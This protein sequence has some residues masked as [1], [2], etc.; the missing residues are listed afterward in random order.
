MKTKLFR[1]TI[2]KQSA[3]PLLAV[4]VLALAASVAMA[5]PAPSSSRNLALLVGCQEYEHA[6][7]LEYIRRDVEQLGSTLVA[8]GD[9][10]SEDVWTLH[11]DAGAD[12]RPTGAA[13]KKAIQG[14]L[15]LPRGVNDRILVYFSGHGFRT[16][17]DKLYLAPVDCDPKTPEGTGIA[18]EWLRQ[19]L[20]ACPAKTKLLVLDACHS[21]SER[22][23]GIST[24][25]ATSEDIGHQFGDLADVVTIASST[26][27]QPSQLWADKQHSLFTYWLNCG[28]KG[29]ADHDSDGEIDVDELFRFVHR[30]VKRT[31]ELHLHRPQVPVRIVRSAIDGVPVVSRLRPQS[32]TTVLNDIADQLADK[33]IENEVSQVG[34]LEFLNDTESGELL[35]SDFGLLGSY[36]AEQLQQRLVDVGSGYFGVVDRRRLDDAVQKGDFQL[37]D[38]GSNT[39]LKQLSKSAGGM[40]V[41]V[42]GKLK[43]G[44]RLSGDVNPRIL[45]VQCKLTQTEGLADLG[46]AGG[47]VALTEAEW[48]MIGKS[49][50]I[51]ADDRRPERPRPGQEPR[52][53]DDRV[54]RNVDE[55]AQGAHPFTDP[56]YPFRLRIMVDD[57]ERP[58]RAVGN[59]WV[60]ELSKGEEYEILVEYSGDQP[61]AMRL[62]VDGLNTLPER[63]GV[64]GL[65]T[66]IIGKRVSLEN[67]RHWVLDPQDPDT[68]RNPKGVPHW[69]IKGFVSII[70]QQGE[71][72]RFTVVGAA[73][74][75]A[76]RHK[77][78]DQ[79]G[80]ITAA[81]F[82]VGGET[83][84]GIG[85]AAG[86]AVSERLKTDRRKDVGKMLSVV[87][88][89]YVE[90]E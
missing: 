23:T 45:N 26:A 75:L 85:T 25:I 60:V 43:G 16:S 49:A 39:A 42:V 17:D 54:I 27:D 30:H 50:A 13:I 57:V 74:S 70:S 22:S 44:L 52:P 36:C 86:E 48:A 5:E 41:L 6:R 20:A 14:F 8:R 47:L 62:L 69:S 33:L 61:V 82:T 10:R 66:W 63:E 18:I 2:W 81:L 3:R 32:L 72:R 21:G 88:I 34:V 84:R 11:D 51:Q 31:S 1:S 12:R 4:I 59:D 68:V 73:E 64:K 40:P 19:Q 56:G 80:I 65:E 9:Y 28:L 38:L 7:R 83:S 67:A 58:G 46:L 76:A 35:G 29:D 79:I 37:A 87:H 78:S 89:K 71:M 77:F 55:R 15:A 24:K 53:I 90:R